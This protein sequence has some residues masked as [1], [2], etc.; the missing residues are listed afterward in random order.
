MERPS[1]FIE[2][3][4]APGYTFLTYYDLNSDS[5][6]TYTKYTKYG[7]KNFER[8]TANILGINEDHYYSMVN[9]YNK[10]SDDTIQA[11]NKEFLN[12][13]YH[14]DINEMLITLSTLSFKNASMNALYAVGGI[15]ILIIIFTSIYCIKNSFDIS[16][17]EKT[18][19]YAI[20]R[21]NRRREKSGDI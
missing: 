17:T 9:D 3:F 7:V 20:R 16:I 21:R 6:N 19:Q 1:N 4:E 14:N 8:T 18:K 5:Y 11:Y 10:L 12:A 2:S 13:K 15:V